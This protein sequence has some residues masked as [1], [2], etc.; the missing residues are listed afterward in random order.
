MKNIKIAFLLGAGISLCVQ[1]PSTN[2]ITQSLLNDTDIIQG[3]DKSFFYSKSNDPS[4]QLVL[5]IQEFL[6]YLGVLIK[7][8]YL[9]LDKTNFNSA[10]MLNYEGIYY[11]VWQLLSCANSEYDNPAIFKLYKEIQN[12][13]KPELAK[14]N[15]DFFDNKGFIG[16]LENVLVY[17]EDIV[18]L[19]LR[20][21]LNNSCGYLKTIQEAYEDKRIK[22]IEIFSLNHDTLIEQCF[23]NKKI[24]YS[25]G[26]IKED[27]EV[28]IWKPESFNNKLKINLYKLHGSINWYQF[29]REDKREQFIGSVPNFIEDIDHIKDSKNGYL[30]RS[31]K[32]AMLIG[33]F[34]KMF[35]YLSDVYIELNFRFYK[36]L[37]DFDFLVISGYSFNDK[38]INFYIRRFMNSSQ[39]KKAVIIDP[40]TENL[41]KNARGMISNNWD[42]WE[43]PFLQMETINKKFEDV[44]L[45][46]IITSFKFMTKKTL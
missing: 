1:A 33:T 41:K 37:L 44:Q 6:K 39:N 26:F 28:K 36:T 12:K 34:N 18:I 43:F 45:D 38:G 2:Q 22:K 15:K 32:H 42:N 5:L 7:E 31:D 9:W 10:R 13:F 17:I 19:K 14:L 29:L 16:F 27:L 35:G 11:L 23:D 4:K 40:N 20:L 3:S 24:E 46:E 8:Y 21:E 30:S 25:D